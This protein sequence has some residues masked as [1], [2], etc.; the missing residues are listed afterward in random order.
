M[1]PL[2][3]DINWM[4]TINVAPRWHFTPSFPLAGDINWMETEYLRLYRWDLFWFPLAGDINWM[5][6]NTLDGDWIPSAL[7]SHS[8]GTLIE[9]KPIA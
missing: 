8:L 9:W 7:C 5:E 1:F 2:A 3:G 6:T 4:E